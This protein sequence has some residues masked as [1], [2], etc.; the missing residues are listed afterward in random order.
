MLQFVAVNLIDLTVYLFLE[1]SLVS[2]RDLFVAFIFFARHQV[3]QC[4]VAIIIII[5]IMGNNRDLILSSRLN[6][7]KESCPLVAVE[8]SQLDLFLI[9]LVIL[10]SERLRYSTLAFEK[11]EQFSQIRF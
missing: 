9:L 2:I 6:E 7:L 4:I 8:A 5:I 3:A 10:D 11:A 1:R